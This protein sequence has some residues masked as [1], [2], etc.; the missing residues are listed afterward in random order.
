[1]VLIVSDVIMSPIILIG[2]VQMTV[3][4]LLLGVIALVGSTTALADNVANLQNLLTSHQVSFQQL[5]PNTT[6]SAC[7]GG[8]LYT[9]A[10]LEAAM[11]LYPQFLGSTD[12]QTNARELAAFFSNIAH[13]TTG[14]WPTAPI[15]QFAWGLCFSHEAGC[16]DSACQQYNVPSS[17]YPASGGK[18]YYGRG[19]IEISYNYNYGLARDDLRKL[20]PSF[21]DILSNPD[22]VQTDPAVTWDTAI[23][24]WMTP[25]GTKPSA[26]E[27]ITTTPG[28][29]I[30]GRPAGFGLTIDIINGGLECDQPANQEEINRVNHY[31]K[32]FGPKLS[33]SGQDY[34]ADSCA[35]ITPFS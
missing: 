20:N 5:F 26:H 29:L 12:Q 17:T 22:L 6:N 16:S 21:P 33:L 10:G 32:W 4:K 27:A 15:S 9:L 13:E 1:M 14:G 30:N 18:G 28:T 23:W 3:R 8:K 25:Q 24:F 35:S 31:E 11:K 19:P 34:T 2:D 7:N